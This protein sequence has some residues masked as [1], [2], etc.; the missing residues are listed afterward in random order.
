MVAVAWAVAIIGRQLE[1]PAAEEAAAPDPVMAVAPEAEVS[2]PMP[3]LP[4]D[5]LVII[6]YTPAPPPPPPA[7]VRRVV[8]QSGP[9]PSP[10][11][12]ASQGS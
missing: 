8:V 3:T 9:A 4:E 10:T 6:R 11:V 7:V 1:A 12:S 5:G 2:S